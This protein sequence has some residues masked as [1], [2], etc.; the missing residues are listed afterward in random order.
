[1]TKPWN[2]KESWQCTH[3]WSSGDME[4]RTRGSSMTNKPQK[5]NR[6]RYCSMQEE[7]CYWYMIDEWTNEMIYRLIYALTSHKG[8]ALCPLVKLCPLYYLFSIIHIIV[9]DIIVFYIHLPS[10]ILCSQSI[11]WKNYAFFLACS[12]CYPSSNKVTYMHEFILDITIVSP[13]NA[14]LNPCKDPV[15][16]DYVRVSYYLKI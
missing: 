14:S 7:K 12:T 3:I 5:R 4:T 15:D 16:D 13:R 2:K 10:K 11:L 6:N 8:E 9:V 1:M